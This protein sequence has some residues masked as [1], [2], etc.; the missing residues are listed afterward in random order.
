MN[1]PLPSLPV[2]RLKLVLLISS[3]VCLVVLLLA[4]FEENLAGEWR[5]HQESYRAALEARAATPEAR[6]ASL[7]MDIAFQQAFLPEL[8]RVDRCQTCHIGIEDPQ[9]AAELHQATGGNPFYLLALARF[10]TPAGAAP[11]IGLPPTIARTVA[12]ELDRVGD[13]RAFAE[14]AAVVQRLPQRLVNVVAERKS[15][16]PRAD[17]VWDAVRACE[18]ALGEDG[19]VV[20]RASGTEPLVRVMVEAPTEALCE[21]WCARIADVARAELGG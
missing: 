20:V 3:L 11:G 19:R 8:D 7:R 12:A 18:E 14:A 5:D 16:L 17:A 15:E 6:A 1:E 21:E 13:A 4:A 2:Q 10:G 9:Q